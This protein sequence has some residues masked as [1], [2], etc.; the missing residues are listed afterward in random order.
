M[1]YKDL[2]NTNDILHLLVNKLN[3][4]P[5]QMGRS[6]FFLCPFHPDKNP[7]LSFEPQKKIFT[8]FSRGCL[9]A[10]DIFNFWAQYH[11]ISLEESLEEIGRLGYFSLSLLQEKKRQERK[12]KDKT[13]YLLSL[14][15]DIY[16]HNLLTQP[17]REVLNYLK[18][19][20]QI[21][22]ELINHFSLGCSIN[23]R[24]ITNLL[25]QSENDNFSSHELLSTN[26]V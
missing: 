12:V 23:N 13:F 26:L 3:F 19:E 5:K 20:R 6:I 21:N 17:G 9:K 18:S 16:Q 14:I 8:C 2:L 22:S 15:A 24:Q 11:K 1:R 10:S 25:F 4:V 7:S